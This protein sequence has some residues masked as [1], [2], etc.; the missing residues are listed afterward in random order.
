MNRLVKDN[1]SGCHYREQYNGKW[2]NV[3]M[4]LQSKPID[5]I[6]YSLKPNNQKGGRFTLIEEQQNN[7]MLLITV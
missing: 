1:W 4:Y 6:E 5:T 3:G 7:Y 2:R